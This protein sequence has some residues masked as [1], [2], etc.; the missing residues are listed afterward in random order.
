MMQN[1]LLLDE[2]LPSDT[3]RGQVVQSDSVT[4]GT[5]G[6]STQ[7]HSAA[8]PDG[9]SSD[10]A[11]ATPTADTL[12]Q[13]MAQVD[14]LIQD[15]ETAI[16]CT[17]E[18]P[19]QP[20]RK[21]SRFHVSPVILSSDAT[22]PPS[23]QPNISELI[24][25]N[26]PSPTKYTPS[27]LTLSLGAVNEAEGMSFI[28]QPMHSMVQSPTDLTIEQQV[29]YIGSSL[30]NQPLVNYVV[31]PV[32]GEGLSVDPN[33]TMQQVNLATTP[34]NSKPLG[35]EHINTLEQLKIG[36]EN[37]TH[38][39]VVTKAKEPSAQEQPAA[40]MYTP[41]TSGQIQQSDVTSTMQS[42]AGLTDLIYS[43][44]RASDDV[45]GS[46]TVIHISNTVTEQ[47]QSQHSQQPQHF[48]QQSMESGTQ[49]QSTQPPV[50]PTQ[51]VVTPNIAP[52]QSSAPTTLISMPTSMT[53]ALDMD[54]NS[55]KLSQQ[56]SVETSNEMYVNH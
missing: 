47:S 24:E 2:S 5:E 31:D 25:A 16:N 37:I 40:G 27:D 29:Q 17:K 12:N 43:T 6:S 1:I 14:T 22:A 18:V 13:Q 34:Q 46:D 51:N 7:T 10:I 15:V 9:T 26:E 45:T 28:P 48:Y 11:T 56:G 35:P 4:P 21:I 44:R 20:Y 30:E 54:V 41:G 3:N 8:S 36:L 23:V 49:M 50:H 42:N 32:T 33:N 39:H 38:A 53:E 19:R 55:R 52:V